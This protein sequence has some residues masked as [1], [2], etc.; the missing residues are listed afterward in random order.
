MSATQ[1][2]G[3]GSFVSSSHRGNQTAI[4]PR[5][6]AAGA[7]VAL[8][9]GRL[10]VSKA[11]MVPPDLMTEAKARRDDLL[12]ELTTDNARHEAPFVDDPEERAA[13]QAEALPVRHLRPRAAGQGQPQP[14]DYCGCCKGSL[15]WTEAEA[16]KGW[17]CCCCHP[18]A[19]LAP[20]QFRAVA[21]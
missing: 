3:F 1:A 17:R 5:L 6:R 10:I 9:D 21:T 11:S 4:L 12:T 16:P 2:G 14:G 18:P 8:H 19:H 15:W 7:Q 20:G 13:I